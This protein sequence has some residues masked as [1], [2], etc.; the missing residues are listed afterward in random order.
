M[1]SAQLT[2]VVCRCIGKYDDALSKK[3][4]AEVRVLSM[5]KVL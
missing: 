5:V 1:L 3:N 4:R 2:F